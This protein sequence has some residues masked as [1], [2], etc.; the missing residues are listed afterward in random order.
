MIWFDYLL[1]FILILNLYKG[2]REGLLRQVA[3]LTS[4]FIAFYVALCLCCTFGR[5]LEKS[6]KLHKIILTLSQDESFTAWPIETLM[7][8]VAFLLVFFVLC[9]VLKHFARKLRVLNRVPIIGP[10][11]ALL[12]A[13]AGGIKGMLIVFL[14]ISLLTLVKTEFWMN[15][16]ETSAVAALS[17]HYLSLLYGFIFDYVMKRLGTLV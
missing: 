4:F 9:F 5:F 12:G 8:M 17:G 13:V 1:I 11:N 14:I 6:L 16:M 7:N 15:T 3:A 2:L 10:V